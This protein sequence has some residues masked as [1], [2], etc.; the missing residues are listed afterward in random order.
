[1]LIL[2]PAS[3]G[4]F[5]FVFAELTHGTKRDLYHGSKLS[6]IQPP[7]TVVDDGFRNACSLYCLLTV[8]WAHCISRIPLQ[9]FRCHLVSPHSNMPTWHRSHGYTH[10]DS[11]KWK[12]T[13]KLKHILSAFIGQH[14]PMLGLIGSRLPRPFSSAFI[15]MHLPLF[16]LISH[17][18]LSSISMCLHLHS[19]SLICFH[20]ASSALIFRHLH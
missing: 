7:S 15:S 19:S 18:L 10:H 14:T 13:L 6:L 5:S 1:M 4:P 2:F 16:P 3:R 9:L 11:P 20:F 17:H 12:T 8:T